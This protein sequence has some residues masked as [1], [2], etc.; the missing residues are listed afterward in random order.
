MQIISQGMLNI[1]KKQAYK[2]EFK[3][4]AVTSPNGSHLSP[5]FHSKV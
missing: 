1:L 3:W 4:I 2:C 5:N